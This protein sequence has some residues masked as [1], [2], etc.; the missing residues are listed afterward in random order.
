LDK[1]FGQLGLRICLPALAAQQIQ[2]PFPD[3][4]TAGAEPDQ[5]LGGDAGEGPRPRPP[6]PKWG[7]SLARRSPRAG[8]SRRNLGW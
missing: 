4:A 7:G 2:H 8:G 5:R 6:V 1:V 3:R